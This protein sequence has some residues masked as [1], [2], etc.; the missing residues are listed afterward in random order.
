VAARN[1][2]RRLPHAHPA[3]P[4]CGRSPA[5]S[6][7]GRT[8]IRR[9]TKPC[10]RSALA[11]LSSARAA[12][13]APPRH[14]LV[15]QDPSRVGCGQ[16]RS[17]CLSFLWGFGGVESPLRDEDFQKLLVGLVLPVGIEP[18]TSP[19]PG[20]GAG[21]ICSLD[22]ALAGTG[23]PTVPVWCQPRNS[24]IAPSC[25]AGRRCAYLSTSATDDQPPSCFSASRSRFSA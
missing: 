14:H 25:P 4:R 7:I 8:N 10:H 9:S 6:S 23:S 21:G 19:L 20:S 16:V 24:R 22:Q 2:V 12:R 1:Q 17:V 18:T 15:R 5:P 13:R 11:R 3:R